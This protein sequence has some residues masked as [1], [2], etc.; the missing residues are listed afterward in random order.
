MQQT[1]LDNQSAVLSV[2]QMVQADSM[3]ANQLGGS[4]L[5]MQNAALNIAN[6]IKRLCKPDCSL[7]FLCG[8]GNNGGDG[9]LTASMLAAA[10]Y[11]V[12]VIF[13]GDRNHIKQLTGDAL[14]AWQE[15]EVDRHSAN[16]ELFLP[17][18]T[19]ENVVALLEDRA[20]ETGLVIIDAIFGA[21]LSR[22][23]TGQIAEL[24]RTV[25]EF[26]HHCS[27][28]GNR[29]A[30][31]RNAGK[32]PSD[33]NST[34][35][36]LHVLSIDLPS[37]INGDTGQIHAVAIEADTTLSFFRKKP[38]H[39]LLPGSRH[40]G[41][42]IIT[43]IGIDSNVLSNIKPLNPLNYENSI[44]LWLD[45][46]PYPESASHKYTRGHTLVASGPRHSTGAA[47]LAAQAALRTGSGAVTLIGSSSAMD[48]NA[49]H[50]TEV[51]LRC[52]EDT[53]ALEQL[54]SDDRLNALVIGP[55]FGVGA[56]CRDMVLTGIARCPHVVLDADALT[57]FSTDNGGHPEDLFAAIKA[58]TCTVVLT[59]HEGE[60]NRLFSVG[61]STETQTCKLQLAREAAERSG[62]IVILKG[63]DTIIASPQGCCIISTHGLPWLATAG[64]GDVLA[65]T[66]AALLAQSIPTHN[67]ALLKASKAD[68][69]MIPEPHLEK[70]P[71]NYYS[72]DRNNGA[73][74]NLK[75]IAA[76]VW[77]HS[78]A[79]RLI[80]PGLIAGDLPAAYPQVLQS[81][82]KQI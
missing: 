61:S 73:Q 66:V 23:I 52:I 7:L 12:E 59:P 22:A 41:E 10:G 5:L 25:N 37:G 47:R 13:C 11:K 65:G 15:W 79:S 82:I 33:K 81:V 64:S 77:L 14:L 54:L 51:M 74:K 43:Q 70:T 71:T 68:S 69:H 58:S 26:R 6:H 39:V 27:N 3:A 17:E 34:T 20:S 29:P 78:E 35:N 45:C 75:K 30:A 60:F 4:Y 55:G 56:R 46:F 57:S 18:L 62:A 1:P 40:C 16:D 76:A 19:G 31:D 36:E 63:A 42:L 38:G 8:G 72:Q 67:T 9:F 80:G 2:Q 24:I 21:G 44:D 49:A 28:T 32:T 53:Q 50:C 48:I